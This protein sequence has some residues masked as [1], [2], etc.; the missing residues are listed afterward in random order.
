MTLLSSI[1]SPQ[2]A[3]RL[4]R[5]FRIRKRLSGTGDRPRLVVH[6]SHLHLYAQLVDDRSGK[7]LLTLG[8]TAPAFRERVSA[9]GTA[10]ASGS[11][12]RV[13]ASGT[14]SVK[15][16]NVAGAA[17]LGELVAKAATQHGITK[18]AFDRGGYLYH[19]RVKAFAD[20]A[21]QHG[22]EF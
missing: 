12:E 19:G 2:E 1:R 14:A 9:S 6:R 10:S 15:G 18:I 21:R 20:A 17:V 7:T 4:R 22:L 13:G 5:H 8:T 11:R 16:G 3:G